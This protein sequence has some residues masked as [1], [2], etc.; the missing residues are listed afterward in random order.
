M[1]ADEIR[2]N[3][4]SE[5]IIGCAFR[6]LNTLGPGFLEKVYENALAYEMRQAGLAVAQQKGVT[7]SYNGIVVGQYVAD[8]VVE[9]TVVIELKAGKT[10]DPVHTAQCMNYLKATGLHLCLLLNFGSPRLG[11]R[12]VAHEL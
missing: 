8:L 11:I 12:R 2:T 3:R 6:V 10:L 9:E 7:V 1:D 4:V 5:C